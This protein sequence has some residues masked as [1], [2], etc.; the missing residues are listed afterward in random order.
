MKK[1]NFGHFH[2]SFIASLHKHHFVLRDSVSSSSDDSEPGCSQIYAPGVLT[3]SKTLKS[4]HSFL[5]ISPKAPK[6]T[7]WIT[8][9]PPAGQNQ[10]VQ[11][12]TAP[13]EKKPN[14]HHYL[15]RKADP[16]YCKTGREMKY[17]C[18]KCIN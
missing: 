1:F 10:A 4:L 18:C 8:M 3:Q 11:R 15:D 16:K 13:T 9:S 17:S 2:H 14:S 7:I 6:L 5:Q 12:T